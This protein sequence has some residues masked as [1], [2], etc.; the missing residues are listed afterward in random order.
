MPQVFEQIFGR[1]KSNP[2]TIVTDGN[3]YLLQVKPPPVGFISKLLVQQAVGTGVAFKV[4]VLNAIGNMTPGEIATPASVFPAGGAWQMICVIQAEPPLLSRRRHRV[5][6][7]SRISRFS[8]ASSRA[9]ARVDTSP[10]CRALPFW[11]ARA[12][13][14]GVRGPVAYCQ[15]W[16]ARAL[17][18]SFSRPSAVKP[19]RFAR[20]R[21][22]AA[23][24]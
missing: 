9:M 24:R 17:W 22:P 10:V 13:P 7:M 5:A 1:F 8:S 16:A 21:L 3:A 12:L 14:S 11:A 23:I 15:G 20:F 19:R 6:A 2:I 4:D 18:R